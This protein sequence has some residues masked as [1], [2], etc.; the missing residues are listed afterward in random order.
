M[1]KA[2]LGKAGGILGF[3]AGVAQ[4]LIA[5]VFAGGDTVTRSVT[6]SIGMIGQ[7]FGL[8]G[9]GFGG[10]SFVWGLV[11][12][13]ATL[14]ISA[15]LV[16]GAKGRLV[17]IALVVCAILGRVRRLGVRASGDIVLHRG[18]CRPDW[19]LR[20][21]RKRASGNSGDCA[22]NGG[23]SQGSRHDGYERDEGLTDRGLEI[24]EERF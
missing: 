18:H 22:T 3:I 1:D 20:G 16:S 17:G 6:G 4:M 5:L 12:A 21:R 11:F 9:G 19:W 2:D 13:Y 7:L 24:V 14:V 23:G 10:P 15:F 8:G